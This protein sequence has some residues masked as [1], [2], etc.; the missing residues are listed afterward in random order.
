[1]L[2]GA[3]PLELLLV[4]AEN[5]FLFMMNLLLFIKSLSPNGAFFYFFSIIYGKYCICN[6]RFEISRKQ[7]LRYFLMHVTGEISVRC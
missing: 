7:F 6:M 3:I 4:T 2:A 5:V 1:M